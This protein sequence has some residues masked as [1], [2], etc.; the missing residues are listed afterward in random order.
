VIINTDYVKK[1]VGFIAGASVG[2]VAKD[3]VRNNYTPET[4]L[5]AVKLFVACAVVG[6]M[7]AA[8]ARVYT[9]TKVDKFFGKFETVEETQEV[10]PEPE[11]Q[12]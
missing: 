8:Q 6:G 2:T 5:Q 11:T 4:K 7:A 1:G 10:T 3:I 12:E 9:D